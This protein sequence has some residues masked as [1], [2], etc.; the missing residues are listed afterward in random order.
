[1]PSRL[2]LEAMPKPSLDELRDLL[3]Q[4]CMLQDDPSTINE[5]TPLFGPDGLGLD[6]IDALELSLSIEKKYGVP[7]KDPAMAREALQSLG[8]LRGWLEKQTS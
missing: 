6:S 5:D 1:M 7:L 2:D 8:T 4:A 3:S